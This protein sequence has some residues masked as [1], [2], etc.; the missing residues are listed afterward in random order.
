MLDTAPLIWYYGCLMKTDVQETTIRTL[1]LPP[2][3]AEKLRTEGF[4]RRMPQNAIVI[5]ALRKHLGIKQILKGT[6]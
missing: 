2:D 3:V 1:R 5:E 4:M 6:K